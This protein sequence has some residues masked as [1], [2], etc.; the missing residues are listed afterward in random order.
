V[1]PD[2]FFSAQ[3]FD[4]ATLSVLYAAFDRAWEHVESDTDARRRNAIRE[5]MA[6]TILALAKCG[7]TDVGRL[8]AWAIAR[9]RYPVAPSLKLVTTTEP[10]EARRPQFRIVSITPSIGARGGGGPRTGGTAEQS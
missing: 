4:P 2:H 7:E 6:L 3:A 10:Y 1:A 8:T 5:R 9:A